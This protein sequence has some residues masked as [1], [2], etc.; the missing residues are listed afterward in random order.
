MESESDGRREPRTL[1]PDLLLGRMAASDML[2]ELVRVLHT[3][4]EPD[5]GLCSEVGC[6]DLEGLLRDHETE[7]WPAVENLARTDLRFRRALASV[8]AYDSAQFDRR[9]ALLADLGEVREVVVRFTVEPEDFSADPQLS[10]RA[11][12][13]EGIVTNRRL[14]ETLRSVAEW[15]DRKPP[16]AWAGSDESRPSL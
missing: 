1:L 10:W 4:D 14:S 2:I 16:D 7:L 9:S 12:E 11:F 6:G 8:W 13:A 15:L 3:T 5:P